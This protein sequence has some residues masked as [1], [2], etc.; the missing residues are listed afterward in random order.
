MLDLPVR[1]L[2]PRY[3]FTTSGGINKD[4]NEVDR[5]GLKRTRGRLFTQAVFYKVPT[6]LYRRVM[7][8]QSSPQVFER[9]EIFAKI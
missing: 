7:V 4:Q 9:A 6:P 8:A 3:S 2:R 5:D 1:P